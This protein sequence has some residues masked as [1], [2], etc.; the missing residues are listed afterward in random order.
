VTISLGRAPDDA[1]EEASDQKADERQ[2]SDRV[3]HR[4]GLSPSSC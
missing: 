4:A 1:A 3:I 2:E